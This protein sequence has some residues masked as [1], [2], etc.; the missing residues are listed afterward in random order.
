MAKIRIL[1]HVNHNTCEVYKIV[2]VCKVQRCRGNEHSHMFSFSNGASRDPIV[3]NVHKL[4]CHLAENSRATSAQD[5]YKATSL[6]TCC[7]SL[8]ASLVTN[9]IRDLTVECLQS[10]SQLRSSGDQYTFWDCHIKPAVPVLC[11]HSA[12]LIYNIFSRCPTS[13]TQSPAWHLQ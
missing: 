13:Y 12:W 3:C 8:N 5:P 1:N 11:C 4:K 2:R 6:H 7:P 10:Q 9:F